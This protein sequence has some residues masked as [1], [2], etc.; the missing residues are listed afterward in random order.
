MTNRLKLCGRAWRSINKAVARTM[1]FL[2]NLY[3]NSDEKFILP[4]NN[5]NI[6]SWLCHAC[7][8]EG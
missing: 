3:S 4:P 5:I 7:R 6:D 2:I 8:T 1:Q